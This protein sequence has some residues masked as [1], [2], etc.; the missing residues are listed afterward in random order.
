[1]GFVRSK[2]VIITL[3]LALPVHAATETDPQPPTERV[4]AGSVSC[5]QCHEKFYEL[6]ST[7]RH[8]LAMQPYTYEFAQQNVT[9]QNA[10]MKIG[11]Y[12]YRAWIG[13]EEGWV[14]EA[15]PE[16]EKRYGIAQ[17]MGGKNVYYFLAPLERGRL[18]TLPLAYDV[19]AR[20][21]FDLPASGIRHFP[22]SV[23]DTPLP[24]TDP[25]YT[26]N[27]S[28]H[29]CHVSQLSTNYDP[30]A[31]T[32]H[33]RWA[34]PGINCET[35]HGPGQEH[36]RVCEAAPEGQR[37]ADLR[38]ISTRAF[39]PEQI[40]SMCGSCHAKMSPVSP[41]F[42]P[43][44][45][46]FDHFDLTTLEDVDFYPDGRDLGENY[47]M[48]T[49]RMSPCVKGGKLDC[50]HC[51]TSSG[52]YRFKDAGNANAACL[53]CH[54]ERVGNATVHTHHEADSTGNRCVAC[55]MPT[56]EFARM[57]RSDHSMRP[58][59]PAASLE[60][61]SPNA[62][63]LCHDDKGPAWADRF[64]RQWYE[65]DYQAPVLSQARLVA[66]ARKGDWS[67]LDSMLACIRSADRDEVFAASLLRLLRYCEL[68]AKWSTVLQALERDPS[69]LVRAAAAQALDG[70]VT[71]ES[72]GVLV[73]ATTDEYRLVRV[74]AAAA[75]AA[76]PINQLAD[77]HCA[78]VAHATTELLEGLRARPDDYVSQYNLGNHQ[79]QRGDH[80]QA[81]ASYLHA[82]RL[83][84]DFL[85]PV[86]NLAFVYNAVGENEK[87]ETSLRRA[88]ALDPNNAMLHLNLGL[89]LNEMERPREA[90]EAFRR[91]VAVD[92]NAAGAAYNLG[93]MLAADRPFESLRWCRRAYEAA[94]EEGKYAYTYAFYLYHRRE[95]D[96]AV[97][98]LEDMV[99][100]NVPYA[101]AYAFLA[102]IHLERGRWDKALA[103]YRAACGNQ[104]LTSE[105]REA[106]RVMLRKLEQGR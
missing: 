76:V 8:G 32:Y 20:K 65:D 5:R 97:K 100:R 40:N 39:A 37:P 85:P 29:S 31:D 13:P 88:V 61:R 104:R 86:A 7:S 71:G 106:F 19:R 47:T 80:R 69:P 2:L 66:A 50:M 94:P 92:P 63:N 74:R 102:A 55:H 79:M 11:E 1:M 48:T 90:E 72:I 10:T 33:S 15:G 44:E 35:C 58:P 38:I 4:L 105:R 59:A 87:A 3:L 27:T 52:R 9:A 30:K 17:V 34:E 83:R 95:P 16:G 23:A 41:S 60:F 93:V 12:E 98:V 28:C 77:E 18:Q 67:Q 62:C 73:K 81:I 43:G 89:L 103:V 56:T 36:V 21:W 64:V 54:E 78:S 45:R 49:W 24:W 53:P 14:C 99:R 25:M 82:T 68:S 75:L 101:D 70:F 22:G 46:Y 57:K 84:P 96:N 6:W 91:T 42:K 26:F 51:H